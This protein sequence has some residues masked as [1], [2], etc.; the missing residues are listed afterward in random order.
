[1]AI[2]PIHECTPE[3]MQQRLDSMWASGRAS[4]REQ[5]LVFLRERAG[6]LF[7]CGRDDD[8]R[9]VRACVIDFEKAEG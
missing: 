6:R 2:K 1:M 9:L 5:V 8:A 3:E 7:A 4:G